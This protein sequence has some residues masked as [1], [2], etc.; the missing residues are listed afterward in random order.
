MES[1]IIRGVPWL[2]LGKK[3]NAKT[4]AVI[5][6]FAWRVISMLLKK[7]GEVA[8]TLVEQLQEN[9][10]KTVVSSKGQNCAHS[11]LISAKKGPSLGARVGASP[12]AVRLKSLPG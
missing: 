4:C 8:K 3:P 1:L 2:V 10:L 5:R 11:A 6:I 9:K 12:I 7:I